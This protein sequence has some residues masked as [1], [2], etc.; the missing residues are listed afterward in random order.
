MFGRKSLL[1]HLESPLT[2]LGVGMLLA[3][4][5]YVFVGL[6][7]LGAGDYW[8]GGL[9][10]IPIIAITARMAFREWALPYSKFGRVWKI[11][12][13]FNAVLVVGYLIYIGVLFYAGSKV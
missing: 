9:M 6:L 5:A 1:A 13:L 8:S 4:S 11:V 2:P 3:L 12:G 10:L 7:L